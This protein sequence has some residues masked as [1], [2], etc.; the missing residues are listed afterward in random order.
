MQWKSGR[1][2]GGIAPVL[3]QTPAGTGMSQRFSDDDSNVAVL[4]EAE[5]RCLDPKFRANND[6]PTYQFCRL[7]L[8][9]EL[10]FRS[11]ATGK[12]EAI[13]FI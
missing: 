8:K 4:V 12:S 10:E 7:Q 3:P 9:K 13:Y 5:Q 2:G 11:T 6:P 1:G